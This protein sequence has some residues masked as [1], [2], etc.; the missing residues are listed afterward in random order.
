MLPGNTDAVFYIIN[1]DETNSLFSR[2]KAIFL[3][4]ILK[5]LVDVML[6]NYFV[7]PILTG[8]HAIDLFSAVVSSGSGARTIEINLPLLKVDHAE[9]VILDLA[10]RGLVG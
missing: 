7:F 10:N 8:T 3:K 6:E 2:Q 5:S 1:V 4:E 9:E